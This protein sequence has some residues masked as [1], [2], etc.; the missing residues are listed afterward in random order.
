MTLVKLTK[1]TGKWA[2]AVRATAQRVRLQSAGRRVGAIA[3]Y[4]ACSD[5]FDWILEEQHRAWRRLHHRKLQR[6]G[7]IRAPAASMLQG[8]C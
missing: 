2:H 4:G 3:L 6:R 7:I 1:E 8:G 5:H